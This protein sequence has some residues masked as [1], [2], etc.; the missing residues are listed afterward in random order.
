MYMAVGGV[1]PGG[2][3]LVV[4]AELACHRS[5]WRA[6]A[7]AAARRFRAAI[8]LVKTLSSTSA[9]YSSGPVT[10]SMWKRPCR[11]WWPSDRH[12]RA[13]STSSSSADLPLELLVAGG[14]VVA[15]H[16]VGDVGVDVERRGAGRPVAGALL[17]ADRPP[18]ERGAAQPQLRRPAPGPGRGSSAASAARR[19]AASGSV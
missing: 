10:P 16:R 6:T 3:L 18:R 8:R 5:G 15:D 1:A 19:A 9:V 2:R 14:G 13:V 17:A 12:S 4:D 11:S 7:S